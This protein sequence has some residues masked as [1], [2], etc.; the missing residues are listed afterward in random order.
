[1]TTKHTRAIQA[2]IFFWGFAFATLTSPALGQTNITDKLTKPVEQSVA[3]GQESQKQ[4]DQWEQE[5]SDLVLLYEQLQQEHGTVVLENKAL[6]ETEQGLKAQNLALNQQKQASLR[7]QKELFPFV[8][9]IYARL[10]RLVA[11]DVSFL[12]EERTMRLQSLEKEIKNPRVSA[13]EKYRRVMEAVFVEAEYG[14][15]IEVY[16]DKVLMEGKET[17]GNIFR[18]GRVALLFLSLDGQAC[19]R[20]NVA[21]NLWQ[22]LSETHLPAIRSAI[23]I[24]GKRKPVELL[25]LPLGVLALQGDD[26]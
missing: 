12:E 22:P 13:A 25:S 26:Q 9:E 6:I 17:T 11:N 24:G 14:T 7:I 21:Q 2:G 8:Q 10:S 5:R 1:M 20:F 19:A 15:T 16:Q 18:L 3:I 23:E 4:R